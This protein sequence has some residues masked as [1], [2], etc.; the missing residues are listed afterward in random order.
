M[1]VRQVEIIEGRISVDM[2]QSGDNVA[3]MLHAIEWAIE[4]LRSERKLLL[5]R[6]PTGRDHA[7][8]VTH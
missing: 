1:K 2:E 3:D 4:Q 7:G 8:D 5:E 6:Y